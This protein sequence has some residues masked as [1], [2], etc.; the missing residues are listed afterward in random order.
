M[1]KKKEQEL[2]SQSIAVL[3][4]IADGRSYG[5]ILALCPDLTYLDIFRAAEEA[6]QMAGAVMSPYEERMAEIRS[7][8]RRAYE[9]WSEEE[10][11]T[12]AEFVRSGKSV[13]EIAAELQRQPGAIRRRM[14]KHNL[15]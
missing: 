2:S 8:H 11:A 3:K 9:P 4:L 6:L 1:A 5:Q 13:E 10:E 12:L 7:T 14:R 15:V